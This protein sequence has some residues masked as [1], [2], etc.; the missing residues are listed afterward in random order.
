MPGP[1]PGRAIVADG[2]APRRPIFGDELAKRGC[3]TCQTD[4]HAIIYP[5]GVVDFLS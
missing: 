3:V 5:P 4:G 1:N 2:V